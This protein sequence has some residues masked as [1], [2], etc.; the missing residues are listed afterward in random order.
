VERIFSGE[1]TKEHRTRYSSFTGKFLI[2][3]SRT[4]DKKAFNQLEYDIDKLKKKTGAILGF[5]E[6]YD[7][8]EYPDG[9]YGYLLRNA[10]EL[11][12]PIPYLG[13][14]A[15]FYKLNICLWPQL[16]PQ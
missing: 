14:P 3:A 1:K 16:W 13:K 5:A 4:I 6:V 10:K 15:L 2:H 8:E 9:S 12:E 7:V 11:N